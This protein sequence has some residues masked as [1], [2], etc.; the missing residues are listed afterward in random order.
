MTRPSAAN[1]DGGS[2]TYLSLLDH[3]TYRR[4][5]GG[6]SE[7]AGRTTSRGISRH[8]CPRMPKSWPGP[9]PTWRRSSAKINKYSNNNSWPSSW[10]PISGSFGN[11]ADG[12]DAK[13]AQRSQ[14]QWLAKKGITAPHL[15][16]ENGSG[17]SA[18]NGSAPREMAAMLQAAWKSPAWRS[19]SARCRSPG[20]DGAHA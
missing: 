1:C 9:S 14:R 6:R 19:T 2:L 10:V 12:D 5:R 16:M 3:A 13:A 18:P 11:D 17:L 8:R 20:T 7:G 15:V 4:R